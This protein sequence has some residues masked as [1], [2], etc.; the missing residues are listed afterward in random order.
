M[1]VA[2]RETRPGSRRSQHLCCLHRYGNKNDRHAKPPP[3]ELAIRNNLV[4]RNSGRNCCQRDHNPHRDL[5]ESHRHHAAN[6]DSHRDRYLRHGIG[7]SPSCRATRPGA[8]L[9]GGWFVRLPSVAA[10]ARPTGV[11]PRPRTGR[12]WSTNLGRT[13]EGPATTTPTGHESHRDLVTCIDE[14]VQERLGGGCLSSDTPCETTELPDWPPEINP[15]RGTG[16]APTRESDE[17][18]LHRRSDP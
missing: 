2:H 11:P 13:P 7:M 6:S 9:R 14:P 10:S 3:H 17:A 18:S 15:G 1:R 12:Y 5:R 8:P 16:L 4:D